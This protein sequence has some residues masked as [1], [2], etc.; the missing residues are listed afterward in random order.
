[1]ARIIV[2]GSNWNESCTA[3]R[4]MAEN[5]SLLYLE[6]GE[7]PAIMAGAGTVALDIMDE[8]PSMEVLVVPVG[9]G[10]FIA[11]CAIAVVSRF[12]A[13]GR[14]P[15]PGPAAARARPSV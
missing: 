2:A 13:S 5:E 8:L 7:D 15:M 3:A 4:R 6:D 12:V 11:G 9:G 10:N 1:M 14:A